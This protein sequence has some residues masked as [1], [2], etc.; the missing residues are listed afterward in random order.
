M[1]LASNTDDTLL[2]DTRELL[3]EL[4]WLTGGKDLS[5]DVED[6][7]DSDYQIEG[8][9]SETNSEHP[10]PTHCPP[11]VS[12]DRKWA[13]TQEATWSVVPMP[14][15]SVTTKQTNFYV[16]PDCARTLFNCTRCGKEFKT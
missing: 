15:Q 6:S 2:M 7:E 1:G 16:V 3:E 4:I 8:D 14:W 9:S 10:G 11:V 5:S 13:G 12:T